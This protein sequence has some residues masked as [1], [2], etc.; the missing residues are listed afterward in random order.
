MD[1]IKSKLLS[2]RSSLPFGVSILENKKT[3][4]KILFCQKVS[5][6]GT[7]HSL[8]PSH[9]SNVLIP[10]SVHSS[11]VKD[12]IL[13]H[14]TLGTINITIVASMEMLPSYENISDVIQ[15]DGWV[16]MMINKEKKIIQLKFPSEKQFL[17]WHLI[18]S[19]IISELSLMQALQP[20]N[21]GSISMKKLETAIQKALSLFP[22]KHH[23]PLLTRGIK[24]F[25]LKKDIPE[26]LHRLHQNT[27]SVSKEELILFLQRVEDEQVSILKLY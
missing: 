23:F 21:N 11:R 19:E 20:I 1:A 10:C 5:V 2:F 26:I 22:P 17:K 7:V 16:I 13:Y 25:Q 18:L 8:L 9:F 15:K 3:E 24:V 12:Q 14:L 27:Y 6:C 4:E